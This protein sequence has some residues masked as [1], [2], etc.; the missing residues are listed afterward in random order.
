MLLMEINNDYK[1]GVVWQNSSFLVYKKFSFI[2]IASPLPLDLPEILDWYSHWKLGRLYRFLLH[3]SKFV[4]A[5]VTIDI[6]LLFTK[7]SELKL[8]KF[9]ATPS[10][11]L[12]RIESGS[13]DFAISDFNSK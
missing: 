1:F 3:S 9:E 7:S 8:S 4:S 13:V 6:L 2:Y 11:F 5:R 10:I 12:N